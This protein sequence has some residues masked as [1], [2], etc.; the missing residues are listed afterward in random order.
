[1]RL[2]IIQFLRDYGLRQIGELQSPRLHAIKKFDFPMETI[3]HFWDDN[4]AVIGPS[5]V[6]PIIAKLKGKV[7][8]EHFTQLE[9][10]DG[11]PKRTGVLPITLLNDFRKQHRFFKPLRRDESVR[12]NQ[13]NVAL[14][15][16]NMLNPLYRYIASYKATYYRWCNNAATMW[17]GV[18]NAVERFPQWNHFIELHV[19][20]RIPTIA[21]FKQLETSQNQ[22]LLELFNTG[23]L[24]NLFDLYRYLGLERKTSYISKIPKA[25]L[26][27]INF[28]VRVQGSFF[29]IN[30]GKLDEWRTQTEE[31][32]EADA[33][34]AAAQKVALE[35]ND[36]E[37]LFAMGFESYIDDFGME[38]YFKPEVLQRRFISLMT[39]LVEYAHGGGTLIENDANVQGNN[40]LQAFKEI[41]EEQPVAPVDP[42]DEEELDEEK[43]KVVEEEVVE[44]DATEVGEPLS[45]VYKQ[46][47]LDILQV[48]FEPPPELDL[49][50]TTLHI[51]NDEM[52][53]AAVKTLKVE[54]RKPGTPA[55]QEEFTTG[56]EMLDG[57]AKRAY[58]LAKT[59]MISERSFEQAVDQ[60]MSYETMPD[61]FGSGLTVK[62][63]MQY[64]AED[65]TVPVDAFPDKAT[66]MDKAML[67]SV[68]KP[69][70]R[71]YVK[72][73]LPK[74]ILNAIMFVQRQG[75]SVTDIKIRE[76]EDVMNHTQTFTVTVKPVRAPASNLEFT[77]PVIDKDG[78]FLSNGVTYRQRIQRADIPIRKVNPMKVA[79]TSYT[80]KT[81]VLRSERA[82]NNYDKWLTRQLDVKARDESNNIISNPK[83]AEI[84]LSEFQGLPRV[85]T[86]LATK[87]SAFDN[88]DIHFYFNY[89]K[90]E[91]HFQT[92]Y[93][94]TASNVERDGMVL[95]GAY[96]NTPVVVDQQ[97]V[98][99][100]QESMTD[101]EP[102]G[103]I[104]DL[105]GLNLTKAPLES[106]DVKIGGKDI[107]L[108]L[109][110][111]YQFGFNN[112]LDKLGVEY[113]AYPRGT[114]GVVIQPDEWVLAFNDEVLV[115]PRSDY[116]AMLVLGG[117]RRYHKSLR[118][119]SR[120]DFNR[121]D[122]YFRILA[123]Q[124]M[125]ARFLKEIEFLFEAWL[126]PIT[127][128][129]LEE[130]GE[131]TDFEG[132]LYRSVELLM[133][134]W[135]PNEVDGAYMRYRGYERIAG[136]VFSS[137][138]KAVKRFNNREGSA[139][140]KVILDRHEVWR[141][142]N[143]PTVATI[144]D[145][146]PIANLRE[147]EAMTYRGSGGRAA[148]SM[149][150]RTRVYGDNDRGII[151]ESTVD[152][153]D[154]G[155]I[156]YMTPDANFTSMRGLTRTFDESVDA[157][158]K[159]FSTSAL[160]GVGMAHDD[161]KRIGFASIQQQQGLYADGYDLSP[162]R[163][164]YEQVIAQRTSSIFA[165]SADQDGEVIS[166]DKHAVLVKYADGEIESA[167]LGTIHGSAAGVV[168]PHDLVT[169][170]K[171]GDKVKRGD[172]ISYNR[173]YFKKDRYNP[174]QA[175]WMPGVIGVVVFSDNLDTL[176][177]GSVV[178][179]SMA[180][181]LNTQTAD[182]KNVIVRFDQHV[183]DLVKV[184]D[185]LDL[186]SILCIIEDPETAGNTLFDEA[187]IE[188]LK[189]L[190]AA[191]P[192]AKV[193]GTV[194]RIE[195]FYHGDLDDMSD[196][197]RSIAER[198]DEERAEAARQRGRNAHSGEV[199]SSFRIKGQVLEPDSMVIRIYIDHDIPFGTGDKAVLCNQMKTVISRVMTGTNTLEDGTPIDIIF[200][201]TSVEERMVMSPKLIATTSMLL[202]QLSKHIAGVYRGTKHAKAK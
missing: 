147:Q 98:F 22:H 70:M 117:M 99:Y 155:I 162:V 33:I 66:I 109:V 83:F 50:R 137:L 181:K 107:P 154:V 114:K 105:A 144:E 136:Q 171:K 79:L 42:D 124:D 93:G 82:D 149:V 188:T 175:S 95:V 169:D 20:E 182:V 47:D 167:P 189:R 199:D 96:N 36:K 196:N 41:T 119:Y 49:E 190:S 101:L 55:R 129:L 180:V 132:L 85:Y 68:H 15:N 94:I 14:F 34:E 173:K 157:K 166:V 163:T 23:S 123:E 72:T 194:S 58:R 89:P 138:S 87:F 54:E 51:E 197:L 97:G 130:M 69:M 32:A 193:V 122:V 77:I 40:L 64:S 18:A 179:E 111:G 13:Q 63:A 21:Q 148:V 120:Y 1:M 103:T 178:S 159:L 62:E 177:D 118:N 25:A 45:K 38:A 202:K 86:A 90:R 187:S 140:Q 183:R 150:A 164:G 91:E 81:F 106:V 53:E 7:F 125:G 104:V 8:I 11:S 31:E 27:Q 115:F 78:R 184:G 152:S 135:S 156:A 108:G 160:L 73:L 151:S 126:D 198:S 176:E 146:N 131:P 80:N 110:L 112:L 60:A 28:F 100:L 174:N 26:A 128:G 102:M 56:D 75:V 139:D 59:N 186:N 57:V 201:N 191:T 67:K 158:S 29:V 134:D 127:K 24:L 76:N 195:C 143:D 5:Q 153:G 172:T 71:K 88:G 113:T 16:Y 6:D 121:K 3:Y 84:D 65:F 46:F 17:T 10:L 9:T 145:S 74:D 52:S 44:V 185:H 170:L 92:K 37:A 35:N 192:T 142:L 61:P 39:T 133:N 4:T 165:T 161:M 48:T 12:L 43:P 200:G 116:K 141:E 30:L 168:Y 19:P 2:K